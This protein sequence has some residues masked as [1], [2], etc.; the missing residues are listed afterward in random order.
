MTMDGRSLYEKTAFGPLAPV[1][2]FLGSQALRTGATWAATRA[3]P[4]IANG[5]RAAG[6]FV[7]NGLRA[8]AGVGKTGPLAGAARAGRATGNMVNGVNTVGGAAQAVGAVHDLVKAPAPSGPNSTNASATAATAGG[9]VGY[10][11]LQDRVEKLAFGVGNAINVA[12]YG[13]MI[14]ANLVPH[15]HPAHAYLEA[16]GLLGLAGTTGYDLLSG[17]DEWKPGL[18][19]L[20]GLGLFASALH[21]RTKS[22]AEV[23]EG[24]P[25]YLDVVGARDL[26]LEHRMGFA[27]VDMSP[28]LRARGLATKHADE[29]AHADMAAY[30]AALDSQDPEV[31]LRGE[32]ADARLARR[33]IQGMMRMTGAALGASAGH[34]LRPGWGILAGAAAGGLAGHGA[35]ELLEPHLPRSPYEEMP[36]D[37]AIARIR[38]AIAHRPPPID[39]ETRRSNTFSG[40]GAMAGV[41]L[42]TFAA[43][44]LMPGHGL[45]NIAANVLGASLGAGLGVHA[46]QRFADATAK[47]RESE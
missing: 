12:S 9:R 45:K 39:P 40:L 19:D 37:E 46:G 42:G 5:A 8:A 47:L 3:V 29:R 31:V 41:G 24:S 28:V 15:D 2:G 23:S 38:E 10:A 6:S 1:A 32:H 36:H 17:H 44:R 13:A 4:A 21:D 34:A 16:A 27:S 30:R 7:Y 22:A 14:G 18:K 35:A 43:N 20:V 26:S 33:G 11:S 25:R